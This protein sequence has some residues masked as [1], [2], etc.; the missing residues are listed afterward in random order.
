VKS[1]LPITV[2][3]AGALKTCLSAWGVQ[4][5]P[6]ADLALTGE[7]AN[8]FVKEDNRYNADINIRFRLENKTGT[9]L[10]EGVAMGHASTWGTSASA[11]NYIQVLS[12]AMRLLSADLAGNGA[13]QEAWSGGGHKPA[14][15][16][17][18]NDLPTIGAAELKA[19]VLALMKQ[20][21]GTD[22]IVSFVRAR[23]VSPP[24]T[25]EEILDWKKAG[26]AEDVIRAALEPTKSG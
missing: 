3:V 21:V 11:E 26:I 18:G 4:L 22:L 12:D 5:S 17:P 19:K 7:I 13:F 16:G 1:R 23:R 15:A 24:L 9:V 2:F 6:D 10:W 20:G 25:A 14:S 8:F